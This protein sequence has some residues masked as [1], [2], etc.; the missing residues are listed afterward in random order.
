MTV[1]IDPFSSV[2]TQ[3]EEEEDREE[4]EKKNKSSQWKDDIRCVCV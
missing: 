1:S 3:E 2:H 4:Q